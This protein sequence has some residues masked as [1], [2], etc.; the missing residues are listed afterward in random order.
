MAST[1]LATVPK[2]VN[3]LRER[4]LGM[5]NRIAKLNEKA[6]ETIEGVVKVLEVQASAFLF[7]A[8]QG[9][10]YEPDPSK[11]T[12]KPGVHVLGIPVEAIAGVGL[13]VGGFMGVGGTKWSGH[14]E[15]LGNGALAAYVSNLGRGWGFKF[16]ADRK[17]KAGGTTK[18]EVEGEGGSMRDQVAALLEGDE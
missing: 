8:I 2:S 10:F 9:A 15:N 11:P 17:A 6:G 16:K 4:Y 14:L 1:A 5:K 3:T 12:D 7:G 18:G 13:I